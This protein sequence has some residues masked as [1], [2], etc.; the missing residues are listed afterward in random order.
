MEL[1]VIVDLKK[2]FLPRLRQEF[3]DSSHPDL[4][5]FVYWKEKWSSLLLTF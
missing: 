4:N 3:F 2:F 1:A 5:P